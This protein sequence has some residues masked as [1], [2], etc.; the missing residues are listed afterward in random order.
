MNDD[1]E[2]RHDVNVS[3]LFEMYGI[4]RVPG[5]KIIDALRMLDV[6]GDIVIKVVD[7][8]NGGEIYK[9]ERIGVGKWT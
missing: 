7:K 8:D 4:K 6:F 1:F 9:H 2:S 3:I 5:D